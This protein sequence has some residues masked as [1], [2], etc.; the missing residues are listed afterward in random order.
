MLTL[1]KLAK[2]ISK[3]S[4]AK[5][6][7]ILHFAIDSR[8]VRKGGLFFALKGERTDGHYFLKE[9]FSKGAIA[10]VVSQ[11]YRGPSFGLELFFVED[12]LT[13]LQKMG[14]R[15]L[16]ELGAKVIG[17]TGSVGKTTTKEFL[18]AVLKKKFSVGKTEGNQN[19]QRTLP[20]TILN[21]SGKEEL[22]ILEMGMTKKNQIAT[23]VDIAPTDIVVVTPIS[24]CHTAYFETLEGVAAAKAEIFTDKTEF[25]LIHK[26]AICF[27]EIRRRCRL[28]TI[29]PTDV[30]A[31]SPFGRTH[32]TENVSAAI[33]IGSYLGMEKGEINQA[34]SQLKP[35]SHRFEK[36]ERG[37][38]LFIDDTYNAS[39]YSTIAALK[40][41]PLPKKGCRKI[42]VF[43]SMGEL[44][45]FSLSSHLA[46][47]KEAFPLVDLFFCIGKDCKPMVAYFEKRKKRAQ[48]FLSYEA[49]KKAVFAQ[50]VSGDVVL[51]KGSNFHKLWD[52]FDFL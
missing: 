39:P 30:E 13:C 33:E 11:N 2:W 34:V 23:L 15:A 14:K 40:N 24:F 19:S 26:Q 18:Y 16:K 36:R 6:C 35:F 31:P 7:P 28:Y 3:N 10:A 27:E 9:V 51:V 50:I 20:L 42:F 5:D 22:L 12:V 41:L 1:S 29:Y 4:P 25:S 38:V 43:G 47:A 45:A 32:I 37:G 8:N 21:S 17:I 52:L 49:L 48:W 46:V 44:G